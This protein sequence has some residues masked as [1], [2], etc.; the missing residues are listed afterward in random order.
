MHSK[1]RMKEAVRWNHFKNLQFN[2][3]FVRTMFATEPASTNL[4]KSIG[5]NFYSED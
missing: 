1:S 4:I 3:L 5:R 2:I